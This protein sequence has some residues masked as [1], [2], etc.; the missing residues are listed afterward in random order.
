MP[1]DSPPCPTQSGQQEELPD[2]LQ[3]DVVFV[4]SA[5]E[6]LAVIETD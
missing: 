2:D 1:M 5:A 3:G 6:L 4:E